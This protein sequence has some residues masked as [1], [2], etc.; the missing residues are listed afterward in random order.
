MKR[1]EVLVT[2]DLNLQVACC[3]FLDQRSGRGL[4][5]LFL[6]RNRLGRVNLACIEKGK[7][8]RLVFPVH[9]KL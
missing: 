8:R 6:I 4:T 7:S 9:I 5:K 2:A 1:G 3:K